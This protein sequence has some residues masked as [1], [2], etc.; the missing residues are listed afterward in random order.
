MIPVEKYL[1]NISTITVD[2]FKGNIRG[3]KGYVQASGTDW[4][5]NYTVTAVKN[6]NRSIIVEIQN[7]A[8]FAN[9]TNNTPVIFSPSASNAVKFTLS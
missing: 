9:M 6:D 7:T 3:V 4:K 1:T 5:T 2:T 8:A